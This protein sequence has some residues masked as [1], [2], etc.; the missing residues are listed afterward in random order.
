L[1]FRP[2]T[3]A[4]GRLLAKDFLAARLFQGSKLRLQILV[5]GGDAGIAGFQS[6]GPFPLAKTLAIRLPFASYFCKRKS[7]EKQLSL[8]LRGSLKFC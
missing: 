7:R 5:E 4:T 8:F 3:G 2:L 6:D 1:K